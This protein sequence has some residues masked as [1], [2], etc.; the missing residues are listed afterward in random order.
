MIG[1]FVLALA[2]SAAPDPTYVVERVVNLNGSVTRVS[3]FRNGVAVLARRSAG[4]AENVI[5]QPLSKVE[6]QVIEQVV[7]ESYRELER[8]DSAGADTPG[9]GKV[10]LRVAPAG[11]TPLRLR[12]SVATAPSLA[13]ARLTQALDGLEA[14]L[15]QTRVTRE[16]LS[17]WEPAPGDRVE[18]EDGRVVE[19][20]SVTPA[21]DRIVVH[22]QVGEGPASF[23]V[24]DEELR[25]LAVRRVPR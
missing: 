3:V 21:P 11:R 6:L 2:V 5:R 10:E 16:D 19:V 7:E 15:V 9:P 12:Y 13:L 14:R 23:F 24:T 20:L 17:G 22:V 4:Q 8:F 1:A 18:L 25:R